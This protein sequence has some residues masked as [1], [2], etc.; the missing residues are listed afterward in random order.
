MSLD[1]YHAPNS[2]SATTRILLEELGVP[3]TLHALKFAENEQRKPEYMAVNPMGKVPAIVHDGVLVTETAAI[4][5]Y[6][7]DAFPQ[8][9]LAPAIGDRLRGP[10]LRWLAFYAGCM[11]PAFVD[12]ALKREPGRAAMMPY[13]DWD[14]TFQ[15]VLDQ[16]RKGP[17]LLGERYTGADVMW[18]S[19]LGFLT[20]FKLIP[21]HPIIS[22]YLERF[23]ARP[24]VV[25]ARA[26]D[27]ELAAS[28]PPVG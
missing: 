12:R 9:E 11:E 20:S 2:R 23:N 22:P 1:F 3:F 6:L 18:G 24:A 5:I 14:T 26:K 25:A 21:E 16:L 28:L 15:T 13:G 17:W 8:T 27:A 7:C 19:A 10:Y 4:I